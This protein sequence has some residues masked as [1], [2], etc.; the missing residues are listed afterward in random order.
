MDFI[1]VFP[2][3]GNPVDLQDLIS[4]AQKA[5]TLCC[6][7]FHDTTHHHTVHVVT[8]CRTLK[9]GHTHSSFIVDEAI[10]QNKQGIDNSC[11]TYTP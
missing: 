7:A 1:D 8:Y 10:S 4:L 2:P 9:R 5:A 3:N 6:S 11:Y